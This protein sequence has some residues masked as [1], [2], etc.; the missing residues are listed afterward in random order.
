MPDDAEQLLV[1]DLGKR[2][3]RFGDEK[4][5]TEL[6][7]ALTNRRWFKEDHLV[8]FSRRRAEEVINGIRQLLGAPPLALQ[9]SGEEGA[10]S[11]TVAEELG[12]LGWNSEPV[13]TTRDDPAQSSEEMD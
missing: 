5:A 10:V 1:R 4:F 2:R 11:R 12:A 13:D 3:Q 8:G 7:R 6:Y 9:G